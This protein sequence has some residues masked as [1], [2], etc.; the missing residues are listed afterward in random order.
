VL[1]LPSF[2]LVRHASQMLSGKQEVFGALGIT[3][4]MLSIGA[5]GCVV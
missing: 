3:Y 4:A 1:I 2:G 5:L